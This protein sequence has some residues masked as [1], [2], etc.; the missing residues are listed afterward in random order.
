MYQFSIIGE[1]AV[2]FTSTTF[3]ALVWLHLI[4][5]VSL[6]VFTF[7]VTVVSAVTAPAWRA[8][9]AQL[10]PKSEIPAAIGANSVGINVSRAL[11]PALGGVV[12]ATLGI[13]APFWFNGFSNVGVFAALI[14][15]REPKKSVPQHRQH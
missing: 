10:E 3:A 12:A 14:R 6:L 1:S 8:V 9:V 4:T 13:G 11:G 2:T 5:P 7:I 15:W